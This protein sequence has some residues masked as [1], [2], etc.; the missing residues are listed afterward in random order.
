MIAV[1][2]SACIQNCTLNIFIL[3]QRNAFEGY[4]AYR[5]V[6]SMFRGANIIAVATEEELLSEIDQIVDRPELCH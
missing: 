3:Y 4:N 5:C 6:L 2:V 1:R